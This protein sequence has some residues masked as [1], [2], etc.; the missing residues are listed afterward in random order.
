MGVGRRNRAKV[1]PEAQG[2]ADHFLCMALLFC[3]TPSQFGFLAYSE[4][5]EF[6]AF[7]PER[8]SGS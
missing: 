2:G 3:V 5:A 4:V 6:F 7:D 8:K 1:Q